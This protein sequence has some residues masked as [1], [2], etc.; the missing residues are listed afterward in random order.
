MAN[1][2]SAGLGSGLDVASIVSQLV[3]AERA[4]ADQ[5]LAT[6]QSQAKTRISALAAFRSAMSG[7]KTSAEALSSQS[8]SGLKALTAT[9]AN[10]DLFTAS[11]D[12]KAVAGNYAIEVLSLASASKRASQ[13]FASETTVVGSGDVEI[14]VGSSAFT[15]TLQDGANTLA[16]LRTQINAASS[17]TGVAAAIVSDAGGARLLLT[18]QDTGLSH[19]LSVNSSLITTT[20]VQPAADAS[21]KLDGFL[22]SSASNQFSGAVDGLSFNLVKAEPGTTTNLSVALNQSSAISAVQKF[23][24][25]YNSANGFI[26]SQTRY[27]ATNQQGGTLLGDSTIL[28]ASQRLR[29]IAGG[30][31]QGA[32]RFETLSQLGITA[33]TDGTLTVDTAKLTSALASDFNAVQKLFA[34]DQGV[35]TRLVAYSETL[36]GDEGQL[37]VKTDSLN[38]RLSSIAKDQAVVD[39]R[40]E[41]YQARISAQF[42]SLDTLVSQLKSTSDY[43]TQQLANL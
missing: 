23:V 36:L 27:D 42:T 43:L 31:V 19:A 18:S 6:A 9:S 13:V 21:I 39:R 32:G 20:E 41:A 12:S 15:I 7:L 25:A 1:V 10:K 16:D 37:K 5:R 11:A 30:S 28:A 35:A 38:A 3:A 24:A 14:S 40:I 26:V 17:N 2:T 29:A 33:S 22:Y 34:G 4:P 8:G